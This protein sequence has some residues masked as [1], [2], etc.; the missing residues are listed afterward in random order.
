VLDGGT[1]IY[2]VPVVGPLNDSS[3]VLPGSVR[4]SAADLEAIAPNLSVGMAVYFY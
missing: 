4:A 2:S 1:V 3:Y